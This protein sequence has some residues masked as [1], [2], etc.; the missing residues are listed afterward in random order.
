MSFEVLDAKLMT[1]DGAVLIYDSEP[2]YL[3][4]KTIYFNMLDDEWDFMCFFVILSHTSTS[5]STS[6]CKNYLKRENGSANACVVYTRTSCHYHAIAY[7]SI[8]V[9]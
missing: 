7:F 5:T 2:Y 6:T 8:F 4:K 9:L 1:L 3:K